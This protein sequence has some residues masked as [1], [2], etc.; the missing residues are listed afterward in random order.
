MQRMADAGVSKSMKRLA[1]VAALA[2]IVG[3][4]WYLR[5]PHTSAA[6]KPDPPVAKADR[7]K[8]LDHAT[9]L[10]PAERASMAD[11]IAQAQ[12][13]RKAREDAPDPSAGGGHAATSARTQPRL[14]DD[15]PDG[16]GE[17]VPIS[18]FHFSAAIREVIPILG[19]CYDA[20]PEV[21]DIDFNVEL[22]LTGDPDIG[23]II[24][25]KQLFDHDNKPLP[26]KFDDCLRSTFQ[27]L[28]LP[29]LAEGDRY[30]VT[31]PLRFSR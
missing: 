30:K 26:A 10:T 23:T 25:A 19:E 8:P 22:D 29:P 5:R 2:A 11:A 13:A 3:A 4:V 21:P 28:A 14:P 17:A 12:E 20:S 6:A 7:P 31:Y 27:T 1:V 24:D 9:R 16:P 18:K 15:L